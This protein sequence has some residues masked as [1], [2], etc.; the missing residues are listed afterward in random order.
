MQVFDNDKITTKQCIYLLINAAI[1][2]GIL[3]LPNTIAREGNQ[4]GWIFLLTGGIINFLGSLIVALI[5]KKC[6][7]RHALDESE[8]IFGKILSY[9]IK[10]FYTLYFLIIT[11]TVIQI[12]LE[13][14]KIFLLC[15]TPKEF[16]ILN[17][18]LISAYII[19]Y[20][21][22]PLARICFFLTPYWFVPAIFFYL[23]GFSDADFSRLLP[24]FTI[25]F[26]KLISGTYK[27]L[28]S[29]VGFEMLLL[30]SPNLKDPKKTIKI[31]VFYNLFMV[32]FYL[33]VVIMV[34]SSLGVEETKLFVWP[35][36]EMA[37]RLILPGGLFE[38]V[39]A[40]AISLWIIT[41]FTTI[42]SY[43]F[44]ASMCLKSFLGL[45]DLRVPVEMLFPF[46]FILSF[47]PKNMAEVEN[48]L[49]FSDFLTI[50]ACFL[51]PLLY[52]T[53]M[54]TKKL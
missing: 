6:T 11:V 54:K 43:Y 48:W 24:L 18:I 30:I 50:P 28:F 10:F 1:G 52:Y 20:G 12:I 32:L 19:R 41:V 51:L 14:L 40:L 29:L 17:L 36:M 44:A 38:R 2:V 33:F 53:I 8:K 13:A 49:S 47:I 34:F 5:A 3:M 9:P 26:S 46:I 42:S 25:S 15:R 22:E 37:K 4:N 21:I 23:L 16:V 35:G 7:T 45:E 27:S 39:D 31:V